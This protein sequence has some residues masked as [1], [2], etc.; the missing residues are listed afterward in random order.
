MTETHTE[1][2]ISAV[3]TVIDNGS[4]GTRTVKFETGLLA[5]QAAGSVTAYL[6]DDTML[7]SA[8]TA[9]RMPPT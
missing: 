2:V 6:D 3:E 4:F 5:R 9:S 8:T 1:P 7:L